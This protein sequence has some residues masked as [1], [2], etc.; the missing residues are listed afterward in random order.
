MLDCWGVLVDNWDHRAKSVSLCLSDQYVE[1]GVDDGN[2]E[3]EEEDNVDGGRGDA[4]RR[5]RAWASE[6]GAPWSG[7]ATAHDHQMRL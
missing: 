3:E 6:L 7:C 5:T 2:V 4:V 1:V